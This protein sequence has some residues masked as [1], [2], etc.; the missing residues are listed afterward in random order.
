MIVATI[1]F[2]LLVI[3]YALIDANY[4][5]KRKTLKSCP[6]C[7][8][9]PDIETLGTCIDITCCASMGLQKSDV[10]D[11]DERGTFDMETLVYSKEAESKA[12]QAIT[13]SWNRR[14]P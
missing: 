1:A 7:G 12:L 8:E 4:E 13:D 9:Q 10:L 5:S 6:F 11:L 14:T 2:V 3:V